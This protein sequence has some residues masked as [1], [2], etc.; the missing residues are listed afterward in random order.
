MTKS[1]AKADFS[2][3]FE[4]LRSRFAAGLA[5]RTAQMVVLTEFTD[6]DKALSE[7][8]AQAHK[9]A[10]ACGTF[11]YAVL[12]NQAREIEKL[13]LVISSKSAAEQGQ[14]LLSLKH[15]VLE[16]DRAVAHSHQSASPHLDVA[17]ASLQDRNAIWLIIDDDNVAS[18][19]T[20]QF[21]A[22]GYHVERVDSFD[23]CVRRLQ[24]TAPAVLLSD[25]SL[26]DGSSL[27]KQN[28]ML[29]Q[30]SKHQS[31]VMVYS[32]VDQ[33][34]LRITA[35]QYNVDAFF[36]SPIDIPNI[37]ATTTELLEAM[38]GNK[39]KVFI[40]DD[41]T[42]LAQHYALI[43]GAQGIDTCIV[44]DVSNIIEEVLRYQPDLL[45]MDIYMPEYSGMELA[46][47]IRQYPAL[48]RLPI[49]FLSSEGNKQ[50]QLRAMAH[51]ADDFI[52]KPIDDSLLVQAIK[53]RLAR[54]IQLKNLIEKDSLTSLIKHSAIK[55]F[56]VQEFD[57]TARSGSALSIVMVD[58]DRFKSVND[59]Y[60]H[61]VGDLVITALATLLRKRLRKTDRA[62][63][64]GG[65]EFLL[66]LPECNEQ[67][68]KILVENILKAFRLLQFTA[69]DKQFSC[70]FSAG[71]VSTEGN[72][73]D[74]VRQM[75]IAA[76]EALYKAKHDGRDR[77]CGYS[78]LYNGAK[79]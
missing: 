44:K 75:I 77:V 16:L 33:F 49:V 55:E 9:L 31:R 43:L 63:R 11:G 48:R 4:Q 66:V 3:A 62:G 13:A 14:S 7:I 46:G 47:L 8:A 54:S 2:A 79:Q 37:I 25:I 71:V 70:T 32:P 56:A 29:N 40:V 39:G 6:R 17:Q 20:Q 69:R 27:F 50:L 10:G 59:T 23:A 35:A 5:E 73:F 57:R 45:L 18:E 26:K 52:T 74:T 30:L 72:T 53:V 64:F 36:A 15:A 60:G 1:D 12:G 76:D 22:Y 24:Q 19:L 68:A 34:S 67:Q 51:G 61:A 38:H 21:M 42:L 65:E 28:Y 58:I 78:E 41:D